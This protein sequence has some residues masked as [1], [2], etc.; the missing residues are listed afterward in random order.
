MVKDLREAINVLER[1]GLVMRIKNKLSVIHE[2]PFIASKLEHKKV[3]LFENIEGYNI[4]KIAFGVYGDRKRLAIAL[5]LKKETEIYTKL[6]D[7]ISN[8]LKPT[9]KVGDFDVNI[10]GDKVDLGK[11]PIPKFYE[12]DKGPYIT[13]GIVVAKDIETGARNLS[14]HRMTPISRNKLVMRVV[15]RD[16]WSFI[17]KA[18]EI[19]KNLPAAV[20]IGVDPATALAAATTLPLYSDE[21][22]VANSL[23]GG[24]L[25]VTSGL[26]IDIEYP[27]NI[28][29]VLEGEILINKLEEEGPF[30]DI[31]GTYDIIRKQPVFNVHAI[32]MKK[33]PIFQAILPAGTEHKT[34]MGLPREA[35]IYGLVRE[36]TILNDVYLADWGSGWLECILAIKKRH[37][38]EPI[39]AGIA[40]ITAHPS[41]KKVIVVDDDIDIR[42]C[43][44]VY[45]AVINRA[46]PAKDY[47]IIPRAKGSTL[48]HSGLPRSKIIIDATIKGDE[49]LFRKATIPISE[50]VVNVLKELQ[51]NY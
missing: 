24:E 21:L 37:P 35:K 13:A 39:N 43:K 8:P 33:D 11:L 7:A 47:L 6:L 40:A 17:K 36:T 4:F 25:R 9:K 32:R 5:G 50:K 14:Y 41:V 18:R 15:E 19:G 1:I 46:N 12:R 42:N 29:I 2:I 28:E 38:D 22:E 26:E 45:W 3:L 31:T 27:L 23:L 51:D 30:T 20:I 10:I 48:D 34:L 44:D 49:K 16:L